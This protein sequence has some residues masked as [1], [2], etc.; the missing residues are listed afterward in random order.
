MQAPKYTDEQVDDIESTLED[1]VF[2]QPDAI[3]W[4]IIRACPCG[5]GSPEFQGILYD[6]MPKPENTVH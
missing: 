4:V 6:L 2:E 1:W 5:C 3:E